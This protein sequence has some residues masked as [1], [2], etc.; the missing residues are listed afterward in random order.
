MD[1]ED[2]AQWTRKRDEMKQLIE[3]LR[4]SGSTEEIALLEGQLAAIEEHLEA[5]KRRRM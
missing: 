4:A 2:I 5:L 3:K 1:D